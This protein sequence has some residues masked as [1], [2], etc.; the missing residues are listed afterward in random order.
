M[1]KKNE[2][3]MAENSTENTENQNSEMQKREDIGIKI[4]KNTVVSVI[5][6]ILIVLFCLGV[7]TFNRLF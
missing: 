2:G 1:I 6:L 5:L 3:V 4:G 7:R